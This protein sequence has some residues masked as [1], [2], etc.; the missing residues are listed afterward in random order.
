MPLVPRCDV[1]GKE[2]EDGSTYSTDVWV[3]VELNWEDYHTGAEARFTVKPDFGGFK[4]EIVCRTHECMRRALDRLIAK[5]L[6]ESPSKRDTSIDED[7]HEHFDPK[8]ERRGRRKK[9]E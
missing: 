5:S 8:P 4:M 7:L 1:C 6:D 3:F 9:T 2:H